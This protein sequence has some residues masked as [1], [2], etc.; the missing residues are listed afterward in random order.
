MD[1]TLS[2]L[3]GVGKIVREAPE[4]SKGNGKVSTNKQEKIPWSVL[5]ALGMGMLVYGVAESFGP[6]TAITGIIPSNYA[7]FGYSLPYIAGGVGAFL[8]GYM[9][10]YM[11]RKT[12]F[13][14]TIAMLLIGLALYELYQAYDIIALLLISFILVGM[15]A[16]GLESPILAMMSEEAS[17]KTRGSL[18]VITQNFGNLGVA[19]VFIP[20]LL[21]LSAFE[22][23][24]AILLMFIGPLIALVVAWFLVEESTPWSAVKH[25]VN[26]DVEQAWRQ[27][28][29]QA[30]PVKPRGGLSLRFL[31]LILIGIAQD[32][33]FV[34]ATYGV[35]Y[36]YF[37]T[38]AASL[39]PLI[40]G[41]TMVVVGI[42]T[43]LWLVPHIDRRTF[44]TLSYGILLLLWLLLWAFVSFTRS[45]GGAA[46]LAI[47]T[48]IF[49]PVET[50]WGARALLEPELFGT[51]RRGLYVSLV[52]MIVWVTSGIITGILMSGIMVFP[53]NL[54]M[55]ITTIIFAIGL[56]AALVWQVKGFETKDRSLYGLDIFK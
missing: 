35:S 34:Y 43:A 18:L 11:G 50:T 47:M 51:E 6:V 40:G 53:F 52:R 19:I 21:G 27:K 17:A 54:A 5:V 16:I 23:T 29:G 15:S 42:L 26:L 25:K 36:S 7:F 39:V 56:A 33:G 3:D 41:F 49:V 28:D 24:L 4:V 10:D 8:A 1:I 14:V 44:A 30:E 46:L 2:S 55:G 22:Q 9:A 45:T 20:V 31:V 32:V 48:L 13:V 38:S 37:S 12:S